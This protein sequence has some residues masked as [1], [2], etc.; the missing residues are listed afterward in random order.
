MMFLLTLQLTQYV[1]DKCPESWR[2]CWNQ[3]PLARLLT[4][5][6]EYRNGWAATPKNRCFVSDDESHPQTPSSC[7]LCTSAR[8]HEFS[9]KVDRLVRIGQRGP[10]SAF[11]FLQI[12]FTIYLQCTRSTA[13]GG[14]G[15][16]KN[17]NRIGEIGCFESRMTMQKHWPTV[18]LSNWLMD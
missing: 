10:Q 13:R 2:K 15:S 6:S 17:R 1:Q 5:N 12:M 4:H 8:F 18:Q 14:G 16:F 3:N 7:G 11:V 9:M